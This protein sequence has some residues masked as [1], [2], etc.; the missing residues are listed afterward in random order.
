MT[1]IGQE[2]NQEERKILVPLKAPFLL[3]FEHGALCF[4]FVLRPT[5]YGAGPS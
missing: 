4:H 3:L 1:M 5:N 2:K